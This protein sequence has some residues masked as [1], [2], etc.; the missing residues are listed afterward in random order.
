MQ[1]WLFCETQNF[2]KR[3]VS[4]GKQQNLFRI[5]FCE[6]KSETS[7]AGNPNAEKLFLNLM[8]QGSLNLK[9]KYSATIEEIISFQKI[10]LLTPIRFLLYS[11]FKGTVPQKSV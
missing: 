8:G 5:E 7:Y 10:P 6:T 4:F 9:N 11:T 2:V 1:N 3:P